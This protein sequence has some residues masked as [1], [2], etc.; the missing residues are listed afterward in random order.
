MLVGVYQNRLLKVYWV[1]VLFPFPLFDESAY[2]N[3]NSIKLILPIPG[4]PITLS[5][6]S[7]YG[8]GESFERS[9]KA[10]S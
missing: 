10:A 7:A 2:R 1:R 8:V 4:Q 6:N 9:T 5:V 3:D